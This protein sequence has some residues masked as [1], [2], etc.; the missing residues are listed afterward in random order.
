VEEEAPLRARLRFLVLAL[1][2]VEPAHGYALISKIEEVTGG[3]IR[4]SPGTLY[5]IL[6]RLQEEG[7][8]EESIE[9][10]ERGM[11]RVYRITPR[12]LSELSASM[13]RF[14]EVME[15]LAALALRVNEKLRPT[16]ECRL[17]LAS[18]IEALRGALERCRRGGG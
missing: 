4:P 14:L 18:A 6:R 5:P 9:A 7:L 10:G 16:G 8:V 15:K 11:R 1:L 12:G 17:H 3:A 13:G 2:A